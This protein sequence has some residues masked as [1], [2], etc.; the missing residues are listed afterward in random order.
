MSAET[1]IKIKLSEKQEGK[2][3]RVIALIENKRHGKVWTSAAW[4]QGVDRA[5]AVEDLAKRKLSPHVEKIFK[6]AL[7]GL[8]TEKPF[9]KAGEPQPLPAGRGPNA[10]ADPSEPVASSK[11]TP[12]PPTSTPPQTSEV[13]GGSEKPKA[14]KPKTPKTG[15]KQGGTTPESPSSQEGKQSS[16]ESSEAF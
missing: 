15:P 11:D 8:D 3:I 16:S 5:A 7:K 14:E 13:K 6:E 1:N 12:K 4:G 10:K 9:P 2:S